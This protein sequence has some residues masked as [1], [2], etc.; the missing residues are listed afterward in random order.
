[1]KTT[2]AWV[3]GLLMIMVMMTYGTAVAA[4]VTGGVDLYS[5]YV[6]RGITFNDGL[7]AQPSMD[8]TAGGFNFNVW[9]NF[10]IDDYENSLDDGEFSE[11]DLALSYTVEAGPLSVTGGYIEYLFPTTDAGGAPGTREIF[12]DL[13]GEPA[14]GFI[15]GATAY[16]DIDEIE[17]YY[18]TP[19]VG[20]SLAI[21]DEVSLDFGA[22]CGYA[23]EDFALG[24]ESGFHEY[25]FYLGAG[26]QMDS[27]SLSALLGYTDTMDKDVLPEEAADVNFFGGIGL[28][29]NF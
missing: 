11:I 26:Y 13:S 16:Y 27:V 14:D 22:S 10:D 7:V 9:G 5:A 19:Y 6:W 28:S 29:Y 3:S 15:L 24:G 20:Y 21:N 4:E 18:L 1:M 23:G 17:D 2:R 25:T 12:V 8:V